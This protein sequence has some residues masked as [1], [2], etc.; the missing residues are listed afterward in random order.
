M[1]RFCLFQFLVLFLLTPL[2]ADQFQPLECLQKDL[3]FVHSIIK[4]DF[5]GYAD[6]EKIR[7]EIQATFAE[8]QTSMKTCNSKLDYVKAIK[9]YFS[10]LHDP[11]IQPLWNFSEKY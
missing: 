3:P 10:S 11:H 4:E 8:L 9:R 5:S 6:S 1:K 2:F 7:Q